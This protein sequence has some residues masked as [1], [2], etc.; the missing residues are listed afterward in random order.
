MVNL[1]T[2]NLDNII[3]A[4]GGVIAYFGGRKLKATQLKK[5]IEETKIQEASALTSMQ[6]AY[7][8]FVVDQKQRYDEIKAEYIYCRE[9]LKL[10]REQ[11]DKLRGDIK[12]WVN[13]YNELRKE[14]E[15]YKK[16][17]N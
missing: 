12:R 2:E 4:G 13:K 6:N 8:E 9:E 5:E 16:K 15:L 14:F 1:I 3:L 7:N 17:H 10:V 11:S